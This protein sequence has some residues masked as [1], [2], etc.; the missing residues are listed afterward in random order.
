MPK[1]PKTKPFG[2]HGFPYRTK[3]DPALLWSLC[4][5]G[6]A[7]ATLKG[8]LPDGTVAYVREYWPA[9]AVAMATGRTLSAVAVWRREGRFIPA[10]DNNGVHLW[11]AE[12]VDRLLREGAFFEQ[13]VHDIGHPGELAARIDEARGLP[14]DENG[15]AFPRDAQGNPIEL[16]QAPARRGGKSGVPDPLAMLRM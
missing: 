7:L 15:R 1:V 10:H 16:G 9:Q 4:E 6:I 12:D 3:D 5:K 11:A 14:L 8:T 2:P 13:S